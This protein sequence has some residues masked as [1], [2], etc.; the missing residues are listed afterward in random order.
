[1][2]VLNDLLDGLL[3]EGV[4]NDAEMEEVKA[5]AVRK[6]RARVTID[7]VLRKGS[8]PCSVMKALLAQDDPALYKTLGFQ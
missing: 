3:Q 7:M 4:I 2:P 5:E 1:M 8:L 6:D